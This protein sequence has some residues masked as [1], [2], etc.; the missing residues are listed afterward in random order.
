MKVHNT[1]Y[2]TILSYYYYCY[3]WCCCCCCCCCCYYYYYYYY[4]LIISID[5]TGCQAIGYRK[6]HNTHISF[7]HRKQSCYNNIRKGTVIIYNSVFDIHIQFIDC[8]EESSS[9]AYIKN[10]MF[11]IHLQIIVH[12]PVSWFISSCHKNKNKTNFF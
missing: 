7:E 11:T 1:T 8:T 2:Y 4:L 9:A 6:R 5:P 12:T 3:C 10:S